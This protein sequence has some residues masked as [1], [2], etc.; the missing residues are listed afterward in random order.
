MGCGSVTLPKNTDRT[1]GF[2]AGGS[3]G[4]RKVSSL[5]CWSAWQPNTARVNRDDRRDLFE[6]TTYRDQY[7]REK[8]G[9][10]A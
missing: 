3:V 4:V 9:V 5:G 1:R 7:G 10:V 2:I 8:G 6:S